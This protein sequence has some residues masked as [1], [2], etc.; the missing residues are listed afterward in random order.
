MSS[1]HVHLSE[2][3]LTF[4]AK[5]FVVF[6]DAAHHVLILL[7][8]NV[9]YSLDI[10][11]P[12]AK[13]SRPI[14][15]IDG[16]N[17]LDVK[18]SLDKRFLAIQRSSLEVQVVD[19]E[20]TDSYTARIRQK[21]GNQLLR[22]GIIWTD[23]SDKPRSSQDLVL[24]TSLGLEFFKVSASKKTCKQ[25]RSVSNKVVCFWYEPA[26]RVVLLA[27]GSAASHRTEV[28]I[29]PYQLLPPAPVRLPRMQLPGPLLETDVSMV[30][31]YGALFCAHIDQ[32]KATLTLHRITREPGGQH[33]IALQLYIPGSFELS[34]V[35]NLL[36][37]HSRESNISM[38]YDVQSPL[39]DPFINPRPVSLQTPASTFQW[40]GTNEPHSELYVQRDTERMEKL[41]LENGPAAAAVAELIAAAADDQQSASPSPPYAPAWRLLSPDYVLDTSSKSG[42]GRLWRLCVSLPEVVTNSS[43]LQT[44]LPFLL[45]RGQPKP[46]ASAYSFYASHESNSSANASSMQLA[47]HT[48]LDA[49]E[50][51]LR[52]LLALLTEHTPLSVM[53]AV[54]DTLNEG[55]LKVQ[56]ST[57]Q[58]SI[59]YST[60]GTSR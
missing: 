14:N 31:L 52:L 32:K 54:F 13:L 6:Y 38:L 20:T 11:T 50:V 55:Y 4:D 8:H 5:G 30:R 27:I 39:R 36:C 35:D 7:K 12:D 17:V 28:D 2:K 16:G 37:C 29:R 42:T 49:K 3:P 45:R 15:F 40:K 1:G 59:V 18:F 48:G 58:Y 41:Q 47:K 46:L 51:V 60:K 21:Q 24:V 56:Y 26:E 9:Y 19:L 25:S 22:G 23:H 53:S 10:L 33:R 44:L 57:V 43:N 34:S